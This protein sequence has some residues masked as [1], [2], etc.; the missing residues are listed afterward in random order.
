LIISRSR[1]QLRI[2]S[3]TSVNGSRWRKLPLK[4][5]CALS[6]IN[7]ARA[8][9]ETIL[10]WLKL[11]PSDYGLQTLNPTFWQRSSTSFV[12]AL[13]NC[14]SLMKAVIDGPDQILACCGK[15]THD[16]ERVEAQ[17]IIKLFFF[18]NVMGFINL[19]GNVYCRAPHGQSVNFAC[20]KGRPPVS[21]ELRYTIFTIHLGSDIPSAAYFLTITM[22]RI[23][24]MRL[25]RTMDRARRE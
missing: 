16:E 13:A 9:R 22:S 18:K 11:C 3:R 4:A 23:I 2:S 10:D 6:G 1:L 8:W 21:A 20:R 12:C 24:K 17:Q 14:P 5:I 25:C 19:S 7:A 15:G